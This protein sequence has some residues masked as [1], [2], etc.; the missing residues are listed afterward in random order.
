MTRRPE[1]KK[2]NMK[3]KHLL[4]NNLHNNYLLRYDYRSTYRD[5]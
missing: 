5:N 1:S 3:Y 4:R 2:G